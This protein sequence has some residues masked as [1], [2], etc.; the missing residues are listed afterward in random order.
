VWPRSRLGLSGA[1][2]TV[3]QIAA[4]TGWSMDYCPSIVDAYLPRRTALTA[5]ELWETAPQAD[6]IVVKLRLAKR[7]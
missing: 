1:E 4:V 6:S 2:A 3:P 7:R 5:I